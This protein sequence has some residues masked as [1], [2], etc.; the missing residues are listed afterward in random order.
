MTKIIYKSNAITFKLKKYFF[1][2]EQDKLV[3]KCMKK[4]KSHQYEIHSG[5]INK[6]RKKINLEF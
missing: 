5:K 1:D 2:V 3:L 6:K 4:R